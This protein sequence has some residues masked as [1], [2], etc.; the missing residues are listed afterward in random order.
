MRLDDYDGWHNLVYRLIYPGILG[1]MIF[2]F[3]DPLRDRNIATMGLFCIIL[4][5]MFD[6]LHLNHD[7][8]RGKIQSKHL[9]WLFLFGDF[10]IAL[11]FCVAYFSLS[12]ITSKKVCRAD[13]LDYC[14]MALAFLQINYLFIYLYDVLYKSY[15]GKHRVYTH[16]I[17]LP[18]VLIFLVLNLVY[19]PGLFSVFLIECCILF[20]CII[21]GVYVFEVKEPIIHVVD[22]IRQKWVKQ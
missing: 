19:L 2:D 3:A 9:K 6:Y 13:Y 21:Y 4:S 8:N 22:T 17:L 5:Y 1:S 20:T 15:L 18:V 7:L 16:I 10:I 12:Q 11:L 14:V